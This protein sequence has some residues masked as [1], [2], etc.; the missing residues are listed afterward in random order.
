MIKETKKEKI[1]LSEGYRMF[2]DSKGYQ[3]TNP[4]NKTPQPKGEPPKPMPA[5]I[6][7]ALNKS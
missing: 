6:L 3:G 1:I 7:A 2:T 5:S 4:N